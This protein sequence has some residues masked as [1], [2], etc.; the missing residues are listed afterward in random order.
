MIF[1]YSKLF[2]FTI[3]SHPYVK[4]I[5]SVTFFAGLFGWKTS[6]YTRWIANTQWLGESLDNNISRGSACISSNFWIFMVFRYYHLI[7]AMS[8]FLYSGQAEE[9]LGDEGCRWRALEEVMC[10]ACILGRWPLGLSLHNYPVCDLS[11]W[12][13][14][15]FLG[16]HVIVSF[17]TLFRLFMCIRQLRLQSSFTENLFRFYRIL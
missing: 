8:Y 15:S 4:E 13:C 11:L 3:S 17:V 10:F 5:W 12:L 16:V 1:F 7:Y 14:N 9:V 2:H 6:L